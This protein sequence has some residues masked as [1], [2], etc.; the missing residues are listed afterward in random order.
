MRPRHCVTAILFVAGAAIAQA[1]VAAAGQAA[2]PSASTSPARAPATTA[3]PVAVPPPGYVI[4]PDDVL[5]VVFWRDKDMSVE[6]AVRP[7][8]RISLPLLNDVQ[9]AGLTPPQLRDRLTD[10]A[11]RYVE[12]PNVTV[13]VRQINSRKVYVTGEVVK[14]GPYPLTGPTT[15]LQMLATAGGLREY[16]DEKNIVIVRVEDGRTHGYPFNYRDVTKRKNLK[17][18]LE[19]K[20]GDTILVP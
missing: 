12:D 14:P 8:G 10:E 4:G 9:A 19:L 6:V 15:V 11:K 1:S 18:N 7:D 20:P 3:A 17:Q 5:S 2:A 13:M 16:A